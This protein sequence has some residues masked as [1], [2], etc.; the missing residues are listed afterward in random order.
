[1]PVGVVDLLEL[2]QVSQDNSERIAALGILIELLRELL[3]QIAAVSHLGGCIQKGPLPEL[4]GPLLHGPLPGVV[5]EDFDRTDDFA[6]TALNRTDPNLHG[7]PV[8]IF[9]V[10]VNLRATRKTIPDGA[11]ERACSITEAAPGLVNVHEEVIG[12]AFP[13]NF[14]GSESGKVFRCLIP[15]RNPAFPVS[16]VHTIMKVVHHLFKEIVRFI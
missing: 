3:L 10:K 5:I 8:A 13:Q 12:A 16:E 4:P 7:Y 14:F 6:V 1:M 15:V 9:M 11:A 2:V